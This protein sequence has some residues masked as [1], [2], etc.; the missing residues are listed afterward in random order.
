MKF[1]IFLILLLSIF[2]LSGCTEPEQIIREKEVLQPYFEESPD[3]VLAS[4]ELLEEEEFELEKEFF[5]ETCGVEIDSGKY[6]KTIY[7]NNEKRLIVLAE[8][9]KLDLI[10]I[11]TEYDEVQTINDGMSDEPQ[12]ETIYESDEME[13][14]D[15]TVE[16]VKS[17]KSTYLEY[18][19]KFDQMQSFSDYI[20]LAQIYGSQ[21]H[22]Q[23]ISSVNEMPQDQI[24]LIFDLMMSMSSK[25]IDC[26]REVRSL[27]L[28]NSALVRFSESGVG[29]F[30][31]E[32]AYIF[33]L[34]AL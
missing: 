20:V 25:L 26:K 27:G 4:M 34:S 13:K 19:S 2:L 21:A 31:S 28:K 17:A 16:S 9:G 12:T 10:C 11:V 32:F 24:E 8:I 18:K 30:F 1:V 14:I 29:S 22:V 15:E 33:K 23:N 3:L 7:E 6:Y 5:E